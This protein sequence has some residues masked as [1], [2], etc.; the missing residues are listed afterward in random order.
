MPKKI[1]IVPE[2]N[3]IATTR[4]NCDTHYQQAHRLVRDKKTT[5]EELE[6]NGKVKSSNRS[7]KSEDWFLEG[8]E[9]SKTRRIQE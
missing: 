5:W 2:C 9:S 1:C 4:G 3:T 7:K 6:K 8:T